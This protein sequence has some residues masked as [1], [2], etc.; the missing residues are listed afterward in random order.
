MTAER[1]RRAAPADESWLGVRWRQ[2][3]SAPPPV[4][5]AVAANTA[6]AALG[7]ALLLAFDVAASRGLLASGRDLTTLAFAGYVVA[8]VLAGSVLT[9]LWVPLPAR[10]GEPR[11]RSPWS[12]MLGLFAALPICYLALV[13]A[14]HLVRPWLR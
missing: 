3:R 10:A 6:V 1:H 7:A 13:A 14:F 5:R 12:A 11:R 2:F 8:V 9:Y 4:V